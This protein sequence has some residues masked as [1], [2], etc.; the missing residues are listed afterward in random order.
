VAKLLTER[1]RCVEERAATKTLTDPD[2]RNHRRTLFSTVFFS[3]TYEE[4]EIGFGKPSNRTNLERVG[5]K[6]AI[7]RG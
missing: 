5:L 2:A 7:Y 1:Q 4:S 6:K 3:V